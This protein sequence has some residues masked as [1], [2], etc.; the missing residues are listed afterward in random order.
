MSYF[1]LENKL[2]EV[3]H[4]AENG[5]TD[6][7][8]TGI[9]SLDSLIKLK[10][11]YPLFVGGAPYS[12]KTEVVFEF[13]VNCAKLHNWKTFIYCGEGGNVEHIF[14]ELIFKFLQKPYKYATEPEKIH[15]EY[16]ISTHFIICD[17]DNDFTI[18]SYYNLVQQAED[19][20]GIKFDM[21]VFDPFNDLDEEDEKYKGQI[22]KFIAGALKKCR[23][24]SKKNNRIDILVTHI[25]DIKPEKDKDSGKMFERMAFANEW[26]G[27][28]A[29]WRRGFLMILVYRP[30]IFL[31]DD[32]GRPY[33]SNETI[34][35]VQKSK[36]KGIGKTGKISIFFDWKKNIFYSFDEYNQQLYSCETNNFKPLQPNEDFTISQRE[37]MEDINENTIF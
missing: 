29:W 11:G 34:L 20:L 24:V 15:A 23:V 8:S 36:P 10:K 6:L 37:K 33:E 14:Y 1:R 13:A 28:R 19:E 27:G 31:K 17:H 35:W 12:G 3:K 5:L 32:T 16:F 21:T 7:K 4:F 9:A 25:A 22:A 18:E 2:Q 26:A 30:E